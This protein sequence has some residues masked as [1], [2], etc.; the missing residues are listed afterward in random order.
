M[1][2]AT[3]A[4]MTTD[5][6]YRQMHSLQP[7]LI[8]LSGKTCTGKT[9]FSDK[10][11]V[12]C[13]YDVIELD[14]VVNDAVIKPLDLHD[15]EGDVFVSV[16]KTADNAA[17]IDPFVIEA[18]RRI[19]SLLGQHKKVIVDGAIA[20]PAII[21]RIFDS[22]DDL[23]FMYFH[24]SAGSENYVRNITNRF[25]TT[26][27]NHRNGLPNAFWGCIGQDAFAD[28]CKNGAMTPPLV[29]GIHRYA[30]LSSDE[31]M[32]RLKVMQENFSGIRVVTI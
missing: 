11:K 32:K 6:A 13:N 16:Y 27:T 26:T 20:N 14:T 17:W 29:T 22:L 18:Q 4:Y 19:R 24:P 21:H 30:E 3:M 12:A 31:S 10:L 1:P 23:T 7:S 25:K 8:Y 5:E 9:T 15:A 2:H 28:F